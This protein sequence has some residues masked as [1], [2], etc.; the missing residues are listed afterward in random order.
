MDSYAMKL[1]PMT[2]RAFLQAVSG[3][4]L[5][6][7]ASTADAQSP[8]TSGWVTYHPDIE[9]QAIKRKNNRWPLSDQAN[10][11]DWVKYEP[12]SDEFNGSSLDGTKWY[13]HNPTWQGRQPG[14]F[15]PKNVTVKDGCLNLAMRL[16]NPPEAMR[17]QGYHTYTSA[18]VQSKGTVLYGYFEVMAKPMASAGSSAF[19]FYKSD[20]DRW[21]EI[22][23][24]EIG[25]G[26]TGF[27]RRDNIT[28]HVFHTPT[29][30]QHFQIGDAWIAPFNLDAD[31]HV[32]GLEWDEAELK[33]Y[34]DGALIRKGPNTYWHQA[35]TMNFDSET[36]PD[37]F[38]LP[39]RA[40]LP[41]TYRID[42]VRAWK[43]KA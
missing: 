36:M 38:G 1:H 12:M 26:A 37:W 39:K 30:K 3:S 43:R 10:R 35:L 19:W 31:F 27:E 20:P 40:D 41:S 42:Y 9:T 4:A 32:Y 17:S 21:T 2:R 25:G 34:F 13:P 16:A 24:F 7:M 14:W 23:V 22:D 28:V 5:G 8:D 29:I 33:F 15:D 11:S 18:A 6:L